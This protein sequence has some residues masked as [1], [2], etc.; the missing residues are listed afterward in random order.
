MTWLKIDDKLTTHPKWL[1]LNLEAKSLWFHAAVWCAAHNN[2]G[3]LPDESMALHAFAASVP[4]NKLEAAQAMLVRA[5]LWSRRSKK[6]GGGFEINDWLDYQPSKQQVKDRTV[7]DEAKQLRT[8][9]HDW[10]HKSVVGRKVKT[11][12]DARDGLCCRY[13]GETTVITA[14]DRRGPQRRTYDLLDPASSWDM[15]ARALPDAELDRLASMW[16]V[17]CGWCNSIKGSRTPD[18]A[19]MEVRPAQSSR[20]IR[21]VSAANGSG[22]VPVVG[23]GLAGSDLSGSGRHGS[24]TP[25]GGGSSAA[26][27]PSSDLLADEHALSLDHLVEVSS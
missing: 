27:G 8:R 22:A 13:C 10:L 26:P 17:A 12:I 4:V 21:S 1:G 25:P 18:E 5:G 20:G 2:D 23:T 19:E 9:L 6:K 3:A 16:V 7:A 15:E 24:G 11:R 14:G